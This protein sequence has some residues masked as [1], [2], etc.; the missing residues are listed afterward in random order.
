[1]DLSSRKNT[2][3]ISAHQQNF[4]STVTGSRKVFFFIVAASFM[5]L[6]QLFSPCQVS[7]VT[8]VC[9]L[10]FYTGKITGDVKY[11]P[12]YLDEGY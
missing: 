6:L 3:T 11:F 10:L 2:G 7:L 9:P 4:M 5:F 8:F 1:M 12:A